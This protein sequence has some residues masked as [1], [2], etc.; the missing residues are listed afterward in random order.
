MLLLIPEIGLGYFS[1][2]LLNLFT[3]AVKVK[4]TPSA[5]PALLA[6]DQAVLFLRET[7]NNSS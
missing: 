1:F 5:L 2:Q 6:A 3:L 7:L 4:D